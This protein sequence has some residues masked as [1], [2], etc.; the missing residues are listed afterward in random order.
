M[1]PVDRPLAL[2]EVF[3]ETVRIYGERL[4]G[5]LG[6][7]AVMGGLFLIATQTPAP[8][9]VLVVSLAFTACY[10]AA[11]RLAAG[12]RFA[13]SWTAVGMRSP[14]LVVLN[15]VVAIPFGIAIGIQ[16]DPLG[17]LVLLLF[18][19]A[20]LVF[21][22]F[23]IPVAALEHDGESGGWFARLAHALHR[24]VEL[25]RAEFLHA[26]GVVA[27]LLL[28]Y[29]LVAP[30]LAAAL[31]GF[32]ENGARASFFLVQVVLAPFFLLGLAVLYFEQRARAVSSR[33]SS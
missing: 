29:S 19:V 6:I 15:F 25:A 30:L 33:G 31:V 8:V 21:V 24:S 20:W 4:W 3:A 16:G 14:V 18:A 17:E 1:T 23:S 11:A 9:S 12:D 2:G 7:G 32:A 10:A 5:T 26:V 13:D 28:S 27:A 22:G